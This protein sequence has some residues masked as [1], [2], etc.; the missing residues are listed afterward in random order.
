MGKLKYPDTASRNA[1]I[2][3]LE[4]K[5]SEL[6][7][8]QSV[9][10]K[11]QDELVQSN[12]SKIDA[13]RSIQ[14]QL[15]KKRALSKWLIIV[16]IIAIAFGVLFMESIIPMIAIAAAG[17]L[18]III[19]IVVK[20]SKS[21]AALKQTLSKMN[22]EMSEF[23]KENYAFQSEIDSFQEKIDSINYEI[24]SIRSEEKLAY[25]YKW[26]DETS[27]GHVALFVSIKYDPFGPPEDGYQSGK[28]YDKGTSMASFKS[29]GIYMDD[30]LYASINRYGDI[31]FAKADPGTHKLQVAT[32]F[33]TD[34]GKSSFHRASE[35]EPFRDTDASQFV[36]IHLHICSKGTQTTIREFYDFDEFLK[37]IGMR[38]EA[39]IEKYLH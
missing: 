38:E 37:D 21:T 12:K 9:P 30:M 10:K 22:S 7:S 5:R 39:F 14:N 19:G 34:G 2:A 26:C 16:G 11:A 17:V 36:R 13:R 31:C 24:D 33:S 23:D 3:K 6:Q 29:A 28:H 35:P 18:A 8:H 15:D 4:E 32:N 20:V 25:Y 1:A 27:H